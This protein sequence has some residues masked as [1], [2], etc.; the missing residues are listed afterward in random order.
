M[1]LNDRV[2][3]ITPALALAIDSRAK[4][5]VALGERVFNFGASEPDCETP[6][7]IREAASKALVDCRVKPIP[8]EGLLELRVAIAD[9]LA[10]ENK[11]SYQIDQIAVSN[12]ARHSIF[13]ILISLC[14]MGDEVILFSPF[15]PGFPELVKLAGG[16]PVVIRGNDAHGLK[17]SASQVQA[18]V[19]RRTKAMI[20]NNPSNPAGMV[21][22]RDELRALGEV[23]VKHNL[24]I[25]ADEVY[26][27]M[28]YNDVVPVSMGSLAPE[29]FQRTITV[30]GFSNSYG[31]TGW[32]L[33]YCAGPLELVKAVVAIQNHTTSSPNLFAQYGAVAAL[34]GP[35]ECVTRMVKAFDER[36][37]YLCKRLKLMKGLTF[38][39]PEG[40]FFVFPNV[41]AFGR[42]SV[43][44]AKSLLEKEK[45]VVTPGLPFGADEHI[46]LSYACS[47]TD[48]EEGMTRLDRFIR[49]L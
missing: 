21:Y 30:N 35:Q 42:S 49:T 43:D 3:G 17:V 4:A 34:R 39:E 10:G 14:Q 16:T 19:T 27:K 48:I 26:E 23:A 6:D 13:N 36:R 22:S 45:V 1:E 11:L 15:W 7:H 29:I 12:G 46:R 5:L 38:V 8:P 28:T 41:A 44:F 2:R 24:M 20:L 33:G 9:K 18:A 40:A 47:L 32:K 25:I 31:M 37:R